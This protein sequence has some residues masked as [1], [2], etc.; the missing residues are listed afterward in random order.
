M[1]IHELI[2]LDLLSIYVFITYLCIYSTVLDGSYTPTKSPVISL[3]NLHTRM[4]VNKDSLQEKI[5]LA[6]S[7]SFI[8][9]LPNLWED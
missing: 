6:A 9:Q 1:Y 3:I 4:N 5:C 2:D 7:L 8:T